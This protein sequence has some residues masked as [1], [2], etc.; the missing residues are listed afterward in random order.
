MPPKLIVEVLGD[1]S[2]L[3]RSFKRGTSEARGFNTALGSLRVGIGSLVKA[4]LVVEAVDKALEGLNETIHLGLDEFKEQAVLSAQTAAALKSTGNIAGV[5]A[6]QIDELSQS[7]SNLSGIDDETIKSAENVLLSFTNIRNSVGKGNDIFTQATKAVTDFAARTGKDAPAAAILFGKALEDPAKRVGILARAGVVLSD[8]Q[9]KVLKSTEK[10]QGILAAQKLLLAQ[11]ERRF[12]GAA[13]AAGKTLPGALGILRERF[14]DLAGEGVAALA[15]P[16]RKATVSLAAFVVQLTEARGASAKL[17]VLGQGLKSLGSDLIAAAR[18]EIAKIDWGKVFDA[19]KGIGG[20]LVKVFVDEIHKARDFGSELASAVRAQI[21]R[22]DWASVIGTAGRDAGRAL[23]ASLNGIA[24]AV[25]AVNWNRVGKELVDGTAI[26][27]AAVVK[28]LASVNWKAVAEAAMK[29]LAAAFKAAAQIQFAVGKEI[30]R[31]LIKGTTQSLEAAVGAMKNLAERLFQPI[32]EAAVRAVDEAVGILAKIPTSFSVKVK[33]VGVGVGFKNP[34]KG[35]KDSL[36]ATL[37]GMQ[38]SATTGGKGI[39]DAL[40]GGIVKALQDQ[41]AS[42]LATVTG[43]IDTAVKSTSTHAA[44]LRTTARD[45]ATPTAVPALQPV[46]ADLLGQGSQRK[47]ITA[48]QRNTFFD[49]RIQRLIDQASDGSI[50]EQIAKLRAVGGLISARIAATKDVTRRLTLESELLDQITRPIAALQAGAK[51]AAKQAR[52]V[53]A[54]KAGDAFQALLDSFTLKLDKASVTKGIADDL[55]VLASARKGIE[56]RIAVVGHTT[57]LDRDLFENAQQAKSVKDGARKALTDALTGALNF[58]LT[59]AGATRS[60]Q[61]DLAALNAIQANLKKQLS[62]DRGNLD[63]QQQLFDVEQKRR[64]ALKQIR[65]NAV[66]ARN[67]AQFKA[68]GLT[69]TGDQVVPGVAGLK[70]SLGTVTSLVTG[71]FLDT[72]KTRSV[73]QH[74]RQVLSGGLGAVGRDVRSQVQQILDGLDQQL[75]DHAGDQTKFRHLS[76]SKLLS[77]LGLSPEE[78]RS[79]KPVLAQIGRGGTVPQAS[80]QFAGARG[81]GFTV[82]G[83]LHLHGV[84]DLRKFE[85]EIAKRDRS[86]AKLRRGT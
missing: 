70:R 68:L 85:S 45:T 46:A 81:G 24:A 69:A 9:I 4:T 44:A 82:N 38:T 7:L 25:R 58:R 62:V 52:E 12:G 21:A 29:V 23:V 32:V 64:D 11:L 51:D 43:V 34:F 15:E 20:A 59:K 19:A 37:A 39:G 36:D 80:T 72:S 75:K 56:A 83:G 42:I 79:L 86:R 28:F 61:D 74:V 6:K 53:A 78:V 35:L 49:N 1:V 77:G 67:A 5:T 26:A 84:T 66:T 2:G 63:L 60:Q 41:A 47:G 40:T 8:S 48:S 13:E 76:A 57:E 33:G 65:E 55:A 31:L 50:K 30:G 17:S 10:T 22:V 27:V 73:L 16:V 3:E 14:K 54:Q 18:T 71:T